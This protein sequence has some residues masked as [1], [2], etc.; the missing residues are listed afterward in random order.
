MQGD[1][2]FFLYK[3]GDALSCSNKTRCGDGNCQIGIYAYWYCAMDIDSGTKKY[4][5]KIL[6]HQRE[7]WRLW[8]DIK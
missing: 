6:T 4:L 3:V 5:P 8:E 7:I 1:F 2:V